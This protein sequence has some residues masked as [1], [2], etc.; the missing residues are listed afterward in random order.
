V[1]VTSAGSVSAQVQSPQADQTMPAQDFY[2]QFK[3]NTDLNSDDFSLF[4][5]SMRAFL[6]VS[7]T[8]VDAFSRRIA[9][10]TFLFVVTHE[11]SAIVS[12]AVLVTIGGRGLSASE[13]VHWVPLNLPSLNRAQGGWSIVVKDEHFRLTWNEELEALQSTYCSDVPPHACMRQTTRVHPG[14]LELILAEV[15]DDGADNWEPIWK[16]GEWLIDP[17]GN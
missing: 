12:K 3:N 11:T 10:R 17:N 4:P 9:P 8:P 5:A 2:R 6:R 1:L 14:F 13:G 16:D 7:R 15:R